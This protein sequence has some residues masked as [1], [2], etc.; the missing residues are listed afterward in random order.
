[1]DFMHMPLVWYFVDWHKVGGGCGV[2]ILGVLVTLG[3]CAACWYQILREP[4]A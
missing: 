1:M 3:A 4:N 2:G